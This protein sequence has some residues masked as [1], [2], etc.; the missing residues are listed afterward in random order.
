M[1][2]TVFTL[3]LIVLLLVSGVVA[4]IVFKRLRR[5]NLIRTA[6]NL[7]LAFE[8]K[9]AAEHI[10]QFGNFY[11]FIRRPIRR[12][13]NVMIG[14]TKGGK[15]IILEVAFP[16]AGRYRNDSYSAQRVT[17]YP[18]IGNV[19]PEFILEP[20]Q[21]SLNYAG[22]HRYE[23]VVLQKADIFNQYYILHA[24]TG[25]QVTAAFN[26][27]T[28]DYFSEHFDWTVESR[29]G[30]LAIYRAEWLGLPK[31]IPQILDDAEEIRAVFVRALNR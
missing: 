31:D 10:G 16:T 1:N 20:R 24:P 19:L 27:K 29:D 6:T 12:F 15:A 9:I 25:S 26:A 28:I 18:S 17:I 14:N 3:L 7:G 21:I 30:G 2:N 23:Y 11:L 8:D 4:F 13:R 22:L 5:L